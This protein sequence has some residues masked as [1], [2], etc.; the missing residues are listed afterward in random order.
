MPV[1]GAFDR[2]S[3]KIYGSRSDRK[4]GGKRPERIKMKDDLTI[5][6]KLFRWMVLAPRRGCR[7]LFGRLSGLFENFSA[8][9]RYAA[10]L[11]CRESEFKNIRDL[12]SNRGAYGEYLM[13]DALRKE[14]GRWLFG[15]YLPHGRELTEIDALFFCERGLFVLESKNISGR[16][17][18]LR[19]QREWVHTYR[20]AEGLKKRRFFNPMMQN[21]AHRSALEAILPENTP[22]YPMVVFGK[23][24]RLCTEEAKNFPTELLT[25]RSLKKRVRSFKKSV[26]SSGEREKLYALLK[27]YAQIDGKTKSRHIAM[28]TK[29]NAVK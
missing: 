4:R 24:S 16:I 11:F 12:K 15:I 6:R 20:C 21:K 28:V 5:F 13:Y 14:E 26:L 3:V 18:G 22:I 10:S 7:G 2:C 27:P 8:D 23:K 9:R 17:Y 29:R 25:V 1:Q 19:D